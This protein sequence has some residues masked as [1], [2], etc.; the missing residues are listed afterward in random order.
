VGEAKRKKLAEI[1]SI[2]ENPKKRRFIY[3][4][5]KITGQYSEREIIEFAKRRY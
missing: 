3:L 2:Q 1:K 4:L 5:R